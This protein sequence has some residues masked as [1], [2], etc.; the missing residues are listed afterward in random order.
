MNKQ[1]LDMYFEEEK[2][3]IEEK[4]LALEKRRACSADEYS[5]EYIALN[6]DYNEK[7][8]KLVNFWMK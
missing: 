4:N 1:E 5:P 7:I 3:L 2:K 8:H 6:K